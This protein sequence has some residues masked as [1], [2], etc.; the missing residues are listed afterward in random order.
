[1]PVPDTTLTKSSPKNLPKKPIGSD[2]I[3][4]P[5]NGTNPPSFPIKPSLS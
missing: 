3:L 4:T 5:L 1:M 2:H